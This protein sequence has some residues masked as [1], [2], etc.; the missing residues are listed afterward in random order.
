MD[1]AALRFRK[2]TS[3]HTPVSYCLLGRTWHT[4]NPATS[5]KDVPDLFYCQ[6]SSKHAAVLVPLFEASLSCLTCHLQVYMMKGVLEI[7]VRTATAS[8]APGRI[9]EERLELSSRNV[10][11]AC[12]LTKVQNDWLVQQPH[13][14]LL[15][16]PPI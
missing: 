4:V 7:V 16:S 1:A 12:Q 3:T 2:L 6:V 14:W 11:H 15:H 8:A 9:I 5:G 10:Q 13:L